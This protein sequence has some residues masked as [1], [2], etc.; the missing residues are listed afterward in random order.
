MSL[1][2][3]RITPELLGL[4]DE[5]R[6]FTAR[7]GTRWQV[8]QV[9]GADP[10]AAIEKYAQILVGQNLPLA[11]GA[12][13]YGHSIFH[14]ALEAGRY[15]SISWRVDVMEGDHPLDWA[16]TSP[17]TH[18]PWDIPGLK[19]YLQDLGLKGYKLHA[20]QPSSQPAAL[21]HDVW[22]GSNVLI[23]RGVTIGHGAVVGAGSVVTRDVPAYAI[24]AGTPARILRYRFPEDIVRRM[25][26]SAWWQYG[27]EQL[28]PLDMREP[29]AFLDR[30][31]SAVAEGL[32]PLDLPVLHGA[33]IIAA[34]EPVA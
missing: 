16:T 20:Y 19:S 23:K 12:F 22:I 3:I 27:P 7:E 34:G 18:A 15:C 24:V 10:R 2:R 25:L 13:S 11:L 1:T 17:V 29:A 14:T 28:Q 33:E 32:R 9:I 5:F 31:E 21:G 6:L 8:G 4:F 26:A 30:L